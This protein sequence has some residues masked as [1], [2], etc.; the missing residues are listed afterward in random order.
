MKHITPFS[1]L[2][3]VLTSWQLFA[4]NSANGFE[5]KNISILNSATLEFSAVPYENGVVFTSTRSPNRLLTCP[6]TGDVDFS[7]LYFSQKDANGDYLE[8]VA[9]K[10]QINGRYHDGAAT[11]TKKGDKM[12]FSRN[13][14]NGKNDESIIDVKVYSAVLENGQWVH[15]TE[16]PKINGENFTTTH[17]A[18][19]ADETQLYFSSNR[20]GGFG[21]MDLWMTKFENG[22]W[23]DPVNLGA[24]I[25]STGNELF[26]F[27]DENNNLFFSSDSLEGSGGLDIFF[28]KM[29]EDG[30]WNAALNLGAPFNSPGDDVAFSTNTD[31]SEG[32]LTTDRD[33]GLGKDDI[34]SWTRQPG[35]PLQATIVVVDEDTGERLKSASVAVDVECGIPLDIIY[36]CAS[37]D[38]TFITPKGGALAMQVFGGS[39]YI[40]DVAKENYF[41]ANRKATT[42]ELTEKP[43]YI[44]PIKKKK[45][46]APLEGLV[47]DKETNFPINLADV[48]IV[49]TTSGEFLPPLK[50][51]GEGRFNVVKIDCDHVY[52][53]TADKDPY[54]G[55]L[56]PAVG[57]SESCRAGK[58]T[59]AVLRLTPPLLFNVYYNFNKASLREETQPDLEKLYK[60]LVG[61]PDYTV[62]VNSFTDARGPKSYNKG[63]SQRRAQSVVNWLVDR[64]IS[65]DRLIAKGFGEEQPV[66]RCVDNVKC[67]EKEHQMNRR[68]E[69]KITG[70]EHTFEVKSKGKDNPIVDPCR[71][72]KF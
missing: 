71:T 47:L 49:D 22:N 19:S 23:S 46:F 53:I 68:T 55:D 51:D 24:S 40:I 25:N 9:M 35:E 69:F 32:F 3:L 30:A 50:S 41:P 44:I 26:P 1:F 17:P 54:T 59:K 65:A 52:K 45:F 58:P 28:S 60:M 66:N 6:P 56:L 61:H 62:E 10:G 18:L 36:K 7:D 63:L 20:E 14:M 67:T 2:I 72:C 64:G 48:I 70:K 39:N 43:E 21:G 57:D 13:N 42:A 11:F 8:P 16:V 4:Q 37:V 31:G 34:Y 38:T 27:L 12:Y 5:L 29:D 33:D 15:V